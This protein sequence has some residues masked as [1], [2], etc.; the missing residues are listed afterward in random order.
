MGD[1]R[2]RWMTCRSVDDVQELAAGMVEHGMSM[3]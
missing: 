3:A 1:K 2:V